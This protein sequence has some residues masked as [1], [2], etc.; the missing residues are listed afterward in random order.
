[1]KVRNE[2][3]NQIRS[4]SLRGRVQRLLLDSCGHARV[5]KAVCWTNSLRTTGHPASAGVIVIESLGDS[6]ALEL[7]G[8]VHD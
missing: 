7:L 1:M 8:F 6:D 2:N 5:E 3:G 4:A